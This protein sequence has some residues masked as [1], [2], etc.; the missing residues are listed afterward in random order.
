MLARIRI[1]ASGGRVLTVREPWADDLYVEAG[2]ARIP[3]N[4]EVTLSGVWSPG[5]ARNKLSA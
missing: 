5:R 3:D 2:A 4:H 1:P